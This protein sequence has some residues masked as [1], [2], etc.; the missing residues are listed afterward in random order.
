MPDLLDCADDTVRLGGMPVIGLEQS[1][2]QVSWGFVGAFSGFVGL[3][4]WGFGSLGFCCLELWVCGSGIWLVI[5]CG[6]TSKPG[7]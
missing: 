2:T 3:G 7:C 4:F 6:A 1:I 5:A